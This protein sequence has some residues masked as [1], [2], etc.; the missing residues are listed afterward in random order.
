MGNFGGA[1]WLVLDLVHCAGGK[2]EV[3]TIGDVVVGEDDVG[4]D[5]IKLDGVLRF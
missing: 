3:S 2:L 4:V 1:L 5:D